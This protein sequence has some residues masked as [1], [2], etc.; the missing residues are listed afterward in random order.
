MEA[1]DLAFDIIVAEALKSEWRRRKKYTLA[2]AISALIFVINLAYIKNPLF[3]ML[4]GYEMVFFG[5][6]TYS[7]FKNRL[8]VDLNVIGDVSLVYAEKEIGGISIRLE[9]YISGGGYLLFVGGLREKP[10]FKHIIARNVEELKAKLPAISAVIAELHSKMKDFL[11]KN[12][13]KIV[14]QLI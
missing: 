3:G 5:V 8:S 9:F 13:K 6:Y 7:L 1:T 4:M 10:Y 11:E 12:A 2:T 14:A